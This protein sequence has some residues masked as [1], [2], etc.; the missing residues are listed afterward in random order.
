MS[1]AV[2]L[3][4]GYGTRMR[5]LTDG[6]PKHLLPVGPELLIVH[7]LRRLRAAGVTDVVLATGYCGDQFEPVLGDGSTWGLRL[8]YAPEPVPLGTGGAARHTVPFLGRL[9]DDE[10]VV[11]L[12]GDLLTGHDLAMQLTDFRAAQRDRGS[13][14]SLHT[15]TVPDARPYGCV[16]SDDDGRVRAFVEKSPDPPNNRINA[17][18]YVMT[19]GAL[20]AIPGVG[21]VSLEHD[22]FPGLVARGLTTSYSEQAYFRD[23]G[24]PAA[25]VAAS[26]DAVLGRM[27]DPREGRW[28]WVSPD[29]EVA[30]GAVVTGGSA[31]HRMARVAVTAQVTG[32]LLME[33]ASIGEGAVVI[34]SVL[35]P[36]SRVAPGA[37]LEGGALG[38]GM[39]FPPCGTARVAA[40][41]DG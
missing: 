19:R 37:R 11:V 41:T 31:V 27:G 8:A 6:R 30:P 36:G 32:S 13:L 20:A 15:R 29:A 33:G 23:V 39:T 12:N 38:D 3:A 16:V 24:S 22:V 34:D 9:P 14:L 28:A 4:G 1:Y 10:P 26:A 21:A 40:P 7:Q 5:P 35:A 2:V 17:G 25:L 18:T